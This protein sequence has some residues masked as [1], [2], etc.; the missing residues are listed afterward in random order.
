MTREALLQPGLGLR[1]HR[2]EP[3]R[4]RARRRPAGEAQ[5]RRRADPERA[6]A[7]ATSWSPW[8]AEA[9]R[10]PSSQGARPRGAVTPARAARR[11]PTG[12]DG[13]CARSSCCR[14]PR[15]RRRPGA[16][17]SAVV[18][19][20]LDY[21]TQALEQRL[22]TPPAAPAP[23][24]PSWSARGPTRRRSPPAWPRR[25]PSRR[26]RYWCWTPAGPSWPSRRSPR[27]AG[28]LHPGP[29]AR[30]ASPG[31]ASRCRAVRLPGPAAGARPGPDPA[32]IWPATGPPGR[33][34]PPG[35]CPFPR[36]PR[37]AAARR[38]ARVAARASGPGAPTR[39][40]EGA[41]GQGH[42]ASGTG[43]RGHYPG[44]CW[45]SRGQPPLRVGGAG[46]GAGRPPRR[47]R[48]WRR[49]RRRGAWLAGSIAGPRRR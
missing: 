14:S 25:C 15:G 1:V 16:A 28:H 40:P 13:A 9:E 47:W 11:A 8:P 36:A 38:F 17:G 35:A 26:R 42:P 12:P 32:V 41:T 7:W 4:G 20:M 46:A 44:W 49:R 6:R 24:P 5:G 21:R 37:P 30:P 29:P 45:R 3:H 48:C 27:D 18:W 19:L 23:P 2:G 34:A 31:C 39:P 10:A 22:R 43:P 33:R